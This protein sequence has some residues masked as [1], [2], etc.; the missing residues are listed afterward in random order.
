[1]AANQITGTEQASVNA[2]AYAIACEQAQLQKVCFGTIPGCLCVGAIYNSTLHQTNGGQ[3]LTWTISSGA[4][5]PGLKLTGAGASAVISGIPTAPGHFEFTITGVEQS[6]NYMSKTFI[7]TVLS[8]ATTTLPPFMS[9]VPYSFQ[10][11]ASGGSGNYQ[12]IVLSGSLPAGLTMSQSG[13]ISG[14]PQ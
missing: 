14:T 3:N 8:I 9:G 10:L 4:L 7:Y 12:W 11:L 1:V 6:G 2:Q 5:P 13:L